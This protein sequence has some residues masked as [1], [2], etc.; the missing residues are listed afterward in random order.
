[1]NLTKPLKFSESYDPVIKNGWRS[2]GAGGGGALFHPKISPFDK[3]TW[4]ICCDMSETY[5]TYDGGKHWRM[6]HL[7]G[8]VNDIAYHPQNSDIIYAGTFAMYK[9]FDKGLTWDLILPIPGADGVV[10]PDKIIGRVQKIHIDR[11]NPES[12]YVGYHTHVFGHQD[13][14]TLKLVYSLDGGSSWTNPIDAEGFDFR[15]IDM[16]E[17]TDGR[18][19]SVFTDKGFY[20]LSDNDLIKQ[21]KPG[22]DCKWPISHATAGI[23]S[24]TGFTV[25]YV[26]QGV[27]GHGGGMWSDENGLMSAVFRS[28]DAGDTWKRLPDIDM[29]FPD[30]TIS[31]RTI[32][33]L[34]VSYN[35]PEHIYASVWRRPLILPSANVPGAFYDKTLRHPLAGKDMGPVNR[36]GII[37]SDDN[38]DTWNW[39]VAIDLKSPENASIGWYENAYY[40]D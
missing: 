10:A 12:I 39:S 13:K 25:F 31:Q 23:D 14:G 6:L 5:I 24:K 40:V 20:R 16:S 7:N 19:L 21:P 26:T 2:V 36:M 15:Y 3:N 30:K 37:S 29:D 22:G 35:H 38:G 18:V 34:V 1:M 33:D 27:S 11:K 32:K 4:M 17:G 28:F 9:S 8:M